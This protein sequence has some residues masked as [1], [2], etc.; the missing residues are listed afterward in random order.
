MAHFIDQSIDITYIILNHQFK[1]FADPDIFNFRITHFMKRAHYRRPL[2]IQYAFAQSDV[3]FYFSHECCPPSF[4]NMSSYASVKL[5]RSRRNTS[6]SSFC[7]VSLS[8]KRHVSG[9]IS[10]AKRLRPSLSR[11][12]SNLKSTSSTPTS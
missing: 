12:K 9:E 2:R 10:S 5:P 8:H 3:D 1:V 7:F 6:L 11:P 4:A